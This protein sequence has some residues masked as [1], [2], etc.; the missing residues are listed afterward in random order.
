MIVVGL[1]LGVTAL[2]LHPATPLL[3]HPEAVLRGPLTLHR[4]STPLAAVEPAADVEPA[5]RRD[6]YVSLESLSQRAEDEGLDDSSRLL[7]AAVLVGIATGGAVAVFKMSI[8]ATAAAAYNGDA[9]VMPWSDRNL[10]GLF[11]FVPALGGLAVS[12]LRV[13][14]PTGLG[15]G[16]AEHVS[17]VERSLPV[18]PAAS[19]ARGAAAVATLGTGSALGPEGPSVELGVSI[20]RLVSGFATGTYRVERIDADY[21][22]GD[23]GGSAPLLPFRI[24]ANEV[25]G[26]ASLRT[27]RQLLAA[28][29]AAGV[30]AGFNAPLAGV[31]FAL[32]VLSSAVR[33]A[34]V[35]DDVWLTADGDAGQPPQPQVHR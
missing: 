1:A 32:E 19:L 9:V 16:L 25:T 29:A 28:G 8:A 10:G 18:R 17:E 14:S 11:V 24:T 26:A 6:G 23:S 33:S 31:F 7:A 34:A 5:G 27:R 12:A 20:S 15:P 4:R 3:L 2:A 21:D 22:G 13:L 35:L 30:A